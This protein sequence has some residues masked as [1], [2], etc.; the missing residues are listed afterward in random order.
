MARD[1]GRNAL[2]HRPHAWGISTEH[3]DAM[4]VHDI[5]TDSSTWRIVDAQLSIPRSGTRVAESARTLRKID[6]DPVHGSYRDPYSVEY[7][8]R[9][10]N[11]PTAIRCLLACPTELPPCHEQ[12]VLPTHCQMCC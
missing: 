3:L 10:A 11:L 4:A 8:S 12:S 2:A 5:A 9:A 6:P 7:R 1:R